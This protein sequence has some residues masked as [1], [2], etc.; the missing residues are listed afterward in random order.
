LRVDNGLPLEDPVPE[1]DPLDAIKSVPLG[2]TTDELRD[3]IVAY[4][5]RFGG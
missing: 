3:A 4:L 5:E 1:E 2:S